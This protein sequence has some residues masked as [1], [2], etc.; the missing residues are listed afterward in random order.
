MGRGL[1][2][3]QQLSGREKGKIITPGSQQPYNSQANDY[4]SPMNIK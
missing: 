4:F 1:Q 2:A 3:K